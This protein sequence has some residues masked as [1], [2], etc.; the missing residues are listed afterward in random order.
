[1]RENPG[2]MLPEED[3]SDYRVQQVS[4][5]G[6]FCKIMFIYAGIFIF[7]IILNMLFQFNHMNRSRGFVLISIKGK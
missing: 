3:K 7:T 1:M 4:T 5:D 2:F 6:M